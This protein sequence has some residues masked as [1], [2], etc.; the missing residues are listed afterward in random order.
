[1]V[2]LEKFYH[3]PYPDTTIFLAA[4]PPNLLIRSSFTTIPDLTI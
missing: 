1:M 2:A 4:L 3:K